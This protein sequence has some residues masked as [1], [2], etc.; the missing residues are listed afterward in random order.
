MTVKDGNGDFF[1][2]TLDQNKDKVIFRD[3][4]STN[5]NLQDGAFCESFHELTN[6][7]ESSIS[8]VWLDSEY[9]SDVNFIPTY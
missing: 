3:A 7:I 1:C 2:G 8:D 6:L 5:S 4:F 9:T